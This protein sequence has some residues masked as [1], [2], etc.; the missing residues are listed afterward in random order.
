MHY[1]L[2]ILILT[3]ARSVGKMVVG[4]AHSEKMMLFWFFVVPTLKQVHYK[5]CFGQT[6]FH[7]KGALCIP[8]IR[9]L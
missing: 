5:F 1:A 7:A 9:L 8:C 4:Q 3:Q 6:F 2:C